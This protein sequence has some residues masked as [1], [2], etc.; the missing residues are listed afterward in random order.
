VFTARYA[1][2]PYIKQIGFVYKGLMRATYL[3]VKSRC[4]KGTGRTAR[5]GKTMF[6][7]YNSIGRPYLGGK[8]ADD[9]IHRNS[10]RVC[11]VVLVTVKG[12]SLLNTVM[13]LCRIY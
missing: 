10:V 2:S 11:A 8:G 1:L 13:Q 3:K 7:S 6:Y 12:R 4:Q 9:R 5:T